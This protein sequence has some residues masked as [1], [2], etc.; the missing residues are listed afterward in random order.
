M[1]IKNKNRTTLRV[2]LTN[3]VYVKNKMIQNQN[4]NAA[5]AKATQTTGKKAETANRGQ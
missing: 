2:R 1:R 5:K 3:C 4:Q